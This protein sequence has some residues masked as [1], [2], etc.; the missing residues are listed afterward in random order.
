M[1][2]ALPRTARFWSFLLAVDQDLAE[3]TRKKACLCGGRLHSANYLRKPRGTP[4]QLPER[5]KWYSVSMVFGVSSL[6]AEK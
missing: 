3:E 1:Y 6:F 4:V 2:H 5:E